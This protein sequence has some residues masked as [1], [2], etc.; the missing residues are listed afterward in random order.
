MF[1]IRLMPP[2]LLVAVKLMKAIPDAIIPPYA[3]I[4]GAASS[5]DIMKRTFGRLFSP[6][7]ETIHRKAG[8]AATKN[9]AFKKLH[10]KA[11]SCFI[12]IFLLLT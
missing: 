2:V 7:N 10:H 12:V 1:L 8:D 9:I 4:D 5:S 11:V 6:A 3:L